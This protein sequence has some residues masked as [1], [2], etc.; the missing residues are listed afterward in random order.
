[1]SRNHLLGF[2]PEFVPLV[3]SG[4]KRQTIRALRKVA[5]AVGDGLILAEGVRT[6]RYARIFADP[7]ACTEVIPVSLIKHGRNGELKWLVA[8]NLTPSF[9]SGLL[10]IAQRDGFDTVHAMTR[11]FKRHHLDDHKSESFH[12]QIIRW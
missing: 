5:I 12:G 8:G 7:A 6:S 2:K 4:A 9:D 3:R 1:M 10:E 11:W